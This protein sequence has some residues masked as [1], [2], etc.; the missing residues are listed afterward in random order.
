MGMKRNIVATACLLALAMPVA[1]A[2]ALTLHYEKPLKVGSVITFEARVSYDEC[3][4]VNPDGSNIVLYH[5]ACENGSGWHSAGTWVP[6]N[7][8]AAWL[9]IDET[10][11]VSLADVNNPDFCF[12]LYRECKCWDGP[13]DVPGTRECLMV[14]YPFQRLE[15]VHSL[16]C[17]ILPNCPTCALFDLSG[18]MESIGNPAD[19][20]QLLLLRG[21]AQVAVLG[22]AGPKRKLPAKA[23]VTLPEA[24][25]GLKRGSKLTGYAL[26]AVDGKGKELAFQKITI[27]VK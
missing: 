10:Y 9:D 22:T 12:K 23:Q 8:G 15:L 6:E 11:T 27:Q 24:K 18:L 3:G 25:S 5:V 4:C 1:A 26:R 14:L 2:G 7:I 13:Q 16:E 17:E 21:E 20:V 19:S